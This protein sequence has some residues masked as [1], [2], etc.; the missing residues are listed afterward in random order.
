[1]LIRKND[2]YCIIGNDVWIGKKVNDSIGE[3]KLV[4]EQL[5]LREL[6]LLKMWNPIVL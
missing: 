5:L 2:R 6:L 4:M 3:L 1:M